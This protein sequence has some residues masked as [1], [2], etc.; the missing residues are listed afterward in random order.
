MRR[1][2]LLILASA[3]PLA[4]PGV[5]AAAFNGSIDA[6]AGRP[7]DTITVTST[8]T[9]PAAVGAT[10]LYLLSAIDSGRPEREISCA[11]EPGGRF[12]G[13]FRQAD[14]GMRVVFTVPSVEPGPYEVRMN[15]PNSSPSCWRLWAF[16]VLPAMPPTDSAR[17][18]NPD[19]PSSDRFEVASVFLAGFAAS[20]LLFW[21]LRRPRGPRVIPRSRGRP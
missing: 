12:L 17:E 19:L 7:G 1:S 3:L 13:A 6:L 14:S 5:V 11:G 10:G 16:E 8:D 4:V 2:R 20:G 9:G 15:V 21:R 18:G